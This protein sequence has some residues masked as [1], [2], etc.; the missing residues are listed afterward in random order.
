LK[1]FLLCVVIR[2]RQREYYKDEQLLEYIGNKIRELRIAKGMSMESFANEFEID[3]SQLSRME[4]GKVNC[5]ISMLYKV[6]E[7]LKVDAKI[8]LPINYPIKK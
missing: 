3:Y 8:L 7:I 6:A 1:L 5:S 2:K 4:L